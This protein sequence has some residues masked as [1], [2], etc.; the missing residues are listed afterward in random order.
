MIYKVYI[1][2]EINSSKSSQKALD[3]TKNVNL[4]CLKKIDFTT[5]IQ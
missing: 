2:K 5:R 1:N 3:I 4:E